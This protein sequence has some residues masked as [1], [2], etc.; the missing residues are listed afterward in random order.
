MTIKVELT[1]KEQTDNFVRRL[2]LQNI[3]IQQINGD[4]C[5]N[6]PVFKQ[7]CEFFYKYASASGGV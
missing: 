6:I 7:I 1:L 4:A 2:K 3:E 5:G